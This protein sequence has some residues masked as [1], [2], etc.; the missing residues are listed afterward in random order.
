MLEMQGYPDFASAGQ[1]VLKLLHDRIGFN[2]WMITRVIDQDWI[3]LQAEDA[4]YGVKEGD[5][6]CWSDSFCSEMVKGNGP[7]IAPQAELVGVYQTAA[8]N[9]KVKIGAYIGMPLRCK[10]GSLFGTLCGIHPNTVSD[11]LEEELPFIEVLVRLLCSLLDADIDAQQERRRAERAETQ[12]QTDA[13]T[14]LYNRQGWDHLLSL[15]E[16]RCQSLGFSACVV[17]IDLD[18]LKK[19]NDTEGHASGDVYLQRSGQVL[20]EVLRKED[21][22]A[23]IG[24]D[25]FVVLGIEVDESGTQALAERLRIALAAENISASIGAALRQPSE[26]LIAAWKQA[27]AEMYQQKRAKKS[28]SA[29]SE[30]SHR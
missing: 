24:G 26:G 12:A 7:Y 11:R 10:D 30:S 19:I 6:F 16:A 13:L 27:D 15:E 2:L 29:L 22:A 23:R 17:I 9:S 3:V 21:I 25:E 18:D 1:A 5:T 8:I 4:G 20:R 14:G 28:L